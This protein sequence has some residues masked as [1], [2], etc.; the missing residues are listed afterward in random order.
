M[1]DAGNYI[2]DDCVHDAFFVP[3]YSGSY[4][5]EGYDASAPR[6][7]WVSLK[8]L[9]PMRIVSVYARMHI[10]YTLGLL[11]CVVVSLLATSLSSLYLRGRVA[12]ASLAPPLCFV[13]S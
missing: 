2:V 3:V 1:A 9:L 12:C 8:I 7:P 4:L 5:P 6:W 13:G 11:L 10:V